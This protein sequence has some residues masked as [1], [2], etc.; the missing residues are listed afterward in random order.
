[1]RVLLVIVG[2]AACAGKSPPT[3]PVGEPTDAAVVPDATPAPAVPTVASTL[4]ERLTGEV[5]GPGGM[6][7]VAVAALQK[8]YAARGYQ[9]VWTA[10]GVVR[11][12]L[13][14]LVDALGLAEEHGLVASE[15]H[16]AEL[17]AVH[18][19]AAA[20]PGSLSLATAVDLELVATDAFFALGGHLVAGLL[21]PASLEEDWK[22]VRREIDMPAVLTEALRNRDVGAALAAL[23][24]ADIG[25]RRLLKAY[26]RYRKLEA[27]GGF[28]AL[29]ARPSKAELAARLDAE[30]FENVRSYQAARGLP[31]TGRLDD[32]TRKAFAVPAAQRVRELRANL[33]RWRWM[34]EEL[35]ERHV[36]VDVPGFELIAR[37]GATEVARARI[38]VGRTYRK[39]PVF[40]GPMTQ[41][42]INPTWT[43]PRTILTEDK[44]PEVAKDVRFLAR[45]HIEILGA[46]DVVVDPA[47]IDW[48]TFDPA[49]SRLRFRM[50]PGPHNPL[51]TLKFDIVN[52]FAVYLHDTDDRTLFAKGVRTFSSGCIRV[53][54]PEVLALW[55]LDGVE[56][57]DKAALRKAIADK[58]TLNV[59]LARPVMVH[60]TYFTARV[61]AEGR[62]VFVEDVYGRDEKLAAALD[63]A[64][65]L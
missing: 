45:N 22:A 1:M 25:Y 61:D 9:P 10:D 29:P 42:V 55:V 33:E 32:A 5:R 21:D 26:A 58:T 35:G 59:P 3:Q 16:A 63:R 11:P 14:Q 47:T 60:L 12:W 31:A 53:Q 49:R 34:P 27:A 23:P 48:A 41:L 65:E 17:G 39:T 46:G 30:G 44:L 18:A 6:E 37:D 51:G 38:V 52:D 62:V 56:G 2:L 7:L 64:V 4:R 20:E 8:F 57:W 15:Y 36:V 24:P 43:I 54:H 28:P 19:S 40:S 13:T 50:T